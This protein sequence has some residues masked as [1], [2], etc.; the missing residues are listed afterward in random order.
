MHMNRE[1]AEALCASNGISL[2]F[3]QR[4]GTPYLRNFVRLEKGTISAERE[5]SFGVAD[6]I[7]RAISE[8][9]TDMLRK[10]RT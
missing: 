3:P 10:I 7:P 9:L 6:D 5:Y 4:Q 1:H 2:S 8:A